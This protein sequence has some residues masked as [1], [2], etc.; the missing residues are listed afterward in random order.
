MHRRLFPKDEL[1]IRQGEPGDAFYLI[2]LGKV[3]IVYRDAAGEHILNQLARGD[4]FLPAAA[5]S[6]RHRRVE[7]V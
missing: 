6:G 3:E 2:R 7:H 5:G 1:I 4:Y